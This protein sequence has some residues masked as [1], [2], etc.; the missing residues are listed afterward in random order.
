ML[1]A[2]AR[3]RRRAD[4]TRALRGGKRAG[5]GALVVHA[6]TP[7]PGDLALTPPAVTRIGFV[8]SRSVGPAVVRNAV[9]RR[10]RHLVRD[11]LATIP[12]GVD[13]VV[14]AQPA[15]ATA[16]YEGLGRDLDAALDRLGLTR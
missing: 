12:P 4:F 1:P 6:R 14:R 15:A 11:R 13:V 10:L 8:V 5:R 16:S 3:L 9:S 7:T 2:T